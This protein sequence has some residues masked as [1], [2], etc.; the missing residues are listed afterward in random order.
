MSSS[1]PES[2]PYIEN[3][4]CSACD[5][6]TVICATVGAVGAVGAVS[7]VG[8]VGAVGARYMHRVG[9][10]QLSNIFFLSAKIGCPL[11]GVTLWLTS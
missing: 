11:T 10:S 8:A 4:L 3:R 1:V 9:K 2:L 6:D 7:A 5:V